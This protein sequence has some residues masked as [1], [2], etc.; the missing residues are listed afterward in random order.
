MKPNRTEP[1]QT[2]SKKLSK[3]LPP[4]TLAGIDPTT[5]CSTS[6]VDAE[7]I[8][9]D[10]AASKGIKPIFCVMEQILSNHGYTYV[11]SI[12][13]FSTSIFHTA[14]DSATQALVHRTNSFQQYFVCT[15]TPG[16][17]VMILKI[18]SPKYLAKILAFFAQTAASFCKN[19]DHNVGF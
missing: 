8:P 1:N 3:K 6:R 10:H 4:Y 7:T 17:D 11:Q 5:H 12:T 2:F 16:T 14:Y 13:I 18:F 19:C 15:A 9:I